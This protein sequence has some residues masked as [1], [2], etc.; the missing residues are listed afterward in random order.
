MGQFP[1]ATAVTLIFWLAGIV[2]TA[3][4]G[5]HIRHTRVGRWLK[6]NLLSSV[7][8]ALISLFFLLILFALVNSIWQWAVVN[9]TFDAACTEPAC[10]NPDGATWGVIISAWDLLMV[11]QFPREEMSRVQVAL[12]FFVV[13]A[14][15]T[16]VA[17]KTG[18]RERVKPVGRL[19]TALWVLSPIVVYIL[20]AGVSAEGPLLNPVTLII[21]EVLV[22]GAFAL[23][24]WQRVIRF[25]WPTLIGWVLAWPVFYVVWRLIGQSELFPPINPALWGGL[26]LTLVIAS[27]VILLSFPLGMALA[28]GRR[29]EIRGIPWWLIWP[30]AIV[31][32]AWGMVTSTPDLLD[33]AQ[34]WWQTLIAFW[35][36]LILVAAVILQRMFQGNVIA[37]TSV[38]FI[39]FVRGVPLITLLFM[40]IIMA[41]FF[42]PEGADIEN[43]VAV[44]LGYALFSAAYMAELIRGGLQA[45]PRG[46]YD[47]ADAIGL[48][49]LQKM[50]FIILPQ[51]ITIVIPG[52]VGQFIGSY[53]SSSLVA[54]VG[55]F[56]LIGIIRVIVA[57]P[58]WIGLRQELFVFAGIIYFT[59]SFIMSWYSRRLESRLRVGQR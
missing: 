45:I 20:L 2:L 7:S 36:V 39:E 38:A 30:V 16:Y 26:L 15:A 17:S 44:I 3:A 32:F 12:I 19:L 59:G 35:P 23:L 5:L 34:F 13:L 55:L 1:A 27:T 6:A 37:A 43:I 40:A 10:R 25:S 42:L 58:Q 18:I 29:S 53:K 14:I 47:A 31:G 9:A 57:N 28:L 54:I 52:I 46:Q 11:G 56:E 8:N 22:L 51:A 4:E 24:W 21:G 33:R 48:N 49:S 41:P 50:R